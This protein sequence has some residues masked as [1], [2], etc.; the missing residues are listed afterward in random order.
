LGVEK[1][2]KWGKYLGGGTPIYG[3]DPAVYPKCGFRYGSPFFV[4]KP[5]DEISRL[6]PQGERVP[7]TVHSP[8]S[9]I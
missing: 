6:F 4:E 5:V 3:R 2:F 8:T 9:R 1:L 7:L